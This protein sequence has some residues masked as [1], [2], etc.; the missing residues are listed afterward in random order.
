MRPLFA[1]SLATSLLSATSLP[2]TALADCGIVSGRVSILS[3]DFPAMHTVAERAEACASDTVTVTRNQSSEHKTIQVPALS[4]NPATYS[5][6][7]VPNNSLPPLLK[8]DLVRPLDALIEKYQPDLPENQ[9][10]RIDGQVM[11]IAFLVNT[12]HL[13]Y[14]ADLLDEAG[15]EV[16]TS[17]EGILLAAEALREQGILANPLALNLKPGWDLGTEFLNLY[18]G[19]GGRLFE[20]DSAEP[21]ID[22]ET[23]LQTLAMLKAL[24]D[25][26]SPDFST[27]DTSEATR[28]WQAGELAF[29]NS[30]SSRTGAIID[31]QGQSLPEVRQNTVFAAAPTVGGNDTP[32]SFLWWVGFT[33][34]R[35]VSDVDAEA[36][37][38]AMMHAISPSLLD[39]HADQAVWLIDGYAP[40]PAAEGAFE[41]VQAGADPYPMLPWLGL[42]QTALSENLAEFLQ[43]RE[44]AEQA[45]ADVVRSYRTAASEAGYLR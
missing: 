11:A 33:I 12:Q 44:S 9:K 40:T 23:G 30:W 29:Y 15:L 35:H 24:S 42:L 14:R 26:M 1:L 31:P 8:D 37:F 6:A 36:S 28:R 41:N 27:F 34:A 32:S 2:Q 25:Y 39:S 21:A 45:L 10:I 7:I 13:W 18:H 20:A 17:Y 4:T 19:F 43:G 3:D 22:G 16:P 5:V 38:Q